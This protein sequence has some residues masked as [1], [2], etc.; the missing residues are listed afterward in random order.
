LAM[1]MF[2]GMTERGLVRELVVTGI[3]RRAESVLW[4]KRPITAGCWVSHRRHTHSHSLTFASHARRS[5]RI[6][7]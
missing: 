5:M 2:D 7:L 3:V 4:Q 1:V 6:I